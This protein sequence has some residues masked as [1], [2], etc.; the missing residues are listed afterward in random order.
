MKS[1]FLSVIMFCI[2]INGW[3]QNQT[4][5]FFGPQATS[6]SYSVF[7]IK[8]DNKTKFGFQAG[9]NMKVPFEGNLYFAPAA[10]YSL[11]G[12]KVNFTEYSYPPSADAKDNNTTLHTF[13]LAA[14]LQYDLG[15]NPGHFFIRTGPSLDFQLIGKE[16]FNLKAGGTVDRNMKF[17]YVDYGHF[18]ANLLGHFGYETADGFFIFL[19]YT[20]GLASINNFD[21][22]PLIRHRAYGIS[23]GRYLHHK[24]K[25]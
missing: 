6:A 17:S 16:K 18:S 20:L 10:F 13:E 22:G 4:G 21:G 12:Y 3:S 11:K 9:V 7:S 15:K 2:F 5:I 8:Q 19:Q 1:G 24:K 25:Q 14:L 23:V